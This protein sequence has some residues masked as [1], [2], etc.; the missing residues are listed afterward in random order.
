MV[1]NLGCTR[2]FRGKSTQ[3]TLLAHNA[4]AWQTPTDSGPDSGK[5]IQQLTLCSAMPLRM[6]DAHTHQVELLLSLTG[7]GEFF[8]QLGMHLS[9][10]FCYDCSTW[11]CASVFMFWSLIAGPGLKQWEVCCPPPHQQKTTNC[12]RHLPFGDKIQLLCSRT[13]IRFELNHLSV[14]PRTRPLTLA[15]LVYC[16]LDDICII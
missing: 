2:S 7:M 11:L 12:V 3:R 1:T 9:P 4:R 8:G 16:Y 15:F 6:L 14:L 5:N 13:R 10:H